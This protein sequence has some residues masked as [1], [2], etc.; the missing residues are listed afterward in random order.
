[1]SNRKRA[2]MTTPTDPPPPPDQQLSD[3]VVQ[4]SP[5]PATW[6]TAETPDPSGGKTV[7]MFVHTPV[8]TATYFL[9]P[10]AAVQ[11]GE[12][13]A[14][15]GRSARVGGGLYLPGANGTPRPLPP[16]PGEGL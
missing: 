5:V 2:N 6:Q 3:G 14:N 1:M 13:I 8:G 11:I 12:N 16:M 10:D 15:S 7:V 4:P 9:S